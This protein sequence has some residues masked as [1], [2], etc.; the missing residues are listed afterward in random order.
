MLIRLEF[1]EPLVESI[2]SDSYFKFGNEWNFCVWK[3]RWEMRFKQICKSTNF[4][5]NTRSIPSQPSA[6]LGQRKQPR[7]EVDT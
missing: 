4:S 1:L 2:V 5:F 3:I 6:W 7:L